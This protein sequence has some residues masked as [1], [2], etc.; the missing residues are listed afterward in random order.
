MIVSVR[1]IAIAFVGAAGALHRPVET[2]VAVAARRF[3][4]VRMV[5]VAVIT[6]M[7]VMRMEPENDVAVRVA[8]NV[9][10]CAPGELER[11]DEHQKDDQQAA[12]GYD[13]T[14]TAR[15]REVVPCWVS[16][17]RFGLRTLEGAE[18]YK[19]IIPAASRSA[20]VT[21]HIEEA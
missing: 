12:H 1:A 10:R 9:E 6:L 15:E 7:V 20:F 8:V 17:A 11:H 4:R 18:R 13:C 14:R 19:Y 2:A 16:M 3:A 5:M 21:K